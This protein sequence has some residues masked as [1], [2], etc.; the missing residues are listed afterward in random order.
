MI[1]VMVV[2][3]VRICV[4]HAELEQAAQVIRVYSLFVVARAV[5]RSW[6]EKCVVAGKLLPGIVW[7]KGVV[8]IDV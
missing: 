7:W 2:A 6:R 4:L 1:V 5:V 3:L 8:G